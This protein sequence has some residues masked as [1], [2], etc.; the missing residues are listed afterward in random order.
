MPTGLLDTP[1]TYWLALAL[2]FC[3]ANANAAAVYKWV[4]DQGVTHYSEKPPQGK[5]PPEVPIRS[6]SAAPATPQGP[7]SG[8]NTWQQ[9]EAEFQQRRVEQEERRTKK[10]AHDHATAENR[11]RACL[12]ARHDLHALEQQRPVYTINAK[13]ER[14]YVEDKDRDQVRERIRQVV[15][16]NC[17]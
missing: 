13:G 16:Q 15:E 4:D 8:P 17:N 7:Q 12:D 1:R 9:Q 14:T 5:K 10:Q 3:T 11:M 6:Q 2:A